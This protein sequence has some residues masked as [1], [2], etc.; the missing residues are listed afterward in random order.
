MVANH[1][2]YIIYVIVVIT[3]FNWKLRAKIWYYR[4]VY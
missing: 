3:T 2:E 4:A 1:D